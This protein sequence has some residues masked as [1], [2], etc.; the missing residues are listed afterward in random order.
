[1]TIT[2]I[3]IGWHKRPGRRS[4]LSFLLIVGACL[5]SCS[6]QPVSPDLRQHWLTLAAQ[7]DNNALYQLGRLSCCGT[8]PGKST[9]AAARW[10]CQAATRGH[11][12]A[13]YELGRLYAARADT[14]W[15]RDLRQDLIFGYT[16][17]GLAAQQNVGLAVTEQFA[18]ARDMT[19]KE[20]S[21]ASEMQRDWQTL[22][23]PS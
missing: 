19:D 10:F 23:C 13:Q 6:S 20:I 15:T 9:I 3:L 5:V 17:F 16:W 11:A 7:G 22:G 1:M 8:G 4:S 14:H 21:I 18:L 2:S 12:L